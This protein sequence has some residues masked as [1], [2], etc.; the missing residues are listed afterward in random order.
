MDEGFITGWIRQWENLIPQTAMENF[1]PETLAWLESRP[2]YDP[3][4][5]LVDPANRQQVEYDLVLERARLKGV[6]HP[7]FATD[8]TLL[9]DE[10]YDG[11]VYRVSQ[12]NGSCQHCAV[13]AMDMAF[14]RLNPGL[15]EELSQK[16]RKG[17]GQRQSEEG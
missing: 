15:F 7:A 2:E 13:K 9:G 10:E 8:P 6:S 4:I 11:L 14:F 12:I 5:R 1:G 3:R 16:G 17:K